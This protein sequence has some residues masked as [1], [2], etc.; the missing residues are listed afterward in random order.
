[1]EMYKKNERTDFIV[2]SLIGI[3]EVLVKDR[4]YILKN[5]SPV[6]QYLNGLAHMFHNGYSKEETQ[7]NCNRIIECFKGHKYEEVFAFYFKKATEIYIRNYDIK[8]E[9]VKKGLDECDLDTYIDMILQ[10]YCLNFGA[11]IANKDA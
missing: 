2:N 7:I 10:E 4:E 1:M 3:E 9:E 8:E 5:I 11:L 6:A